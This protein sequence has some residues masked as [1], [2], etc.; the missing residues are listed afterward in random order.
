MKVDSGHQIVMG[1]F[2]QVV[3]VAEDR[4]AGL[5]CIR[6]AMAEIHKVDELMSDYKGDSDIGRVNEKAKPALQSVETV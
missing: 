5:T 3:V 1:T 2:A 6:A 4:D